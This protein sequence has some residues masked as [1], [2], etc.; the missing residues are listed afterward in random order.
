MK[1]LIIGMIDS[2]HTARWISPIAGQGWNIHLNFI[3]LFITLRQNTLW[4]LSQ[5]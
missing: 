4:S 2:V 1:I 5:G 3:K